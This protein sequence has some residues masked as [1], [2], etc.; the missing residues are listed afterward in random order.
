M[1]TT[2]STPNLTRIRAGVRVVLAMGV[3]ASIAANVLHAQ[4]TA[5]GRA[6]AAWSPL[7]LL[8]TVELISR[9]PVDRRALSGLRMTAT[10]TIAGIAAWVSY[11][12]MV[13]VATRYGEA[14][15]SAH[16]L[17]ENP[18]VPITTA[19]TKGTRRFRTARRSPAVMPR[20]LHP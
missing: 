2:T 11:W 15:T 1:N 14:T 13:S 12:H 10:G 7:A 16:L 17:Y 9:V 18:A 19:K 4:P 6:I 20:P 8:L 5:V 3:A